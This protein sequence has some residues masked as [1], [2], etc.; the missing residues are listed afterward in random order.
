MKAQYNLGRELEGFLTNGFSVLR[1][2]EKRLDTALEY[3]EKIM[4]TFILAVRQSYNEPSD[5]KKAEFLRKLVKHVKRLNLVMVHGHELDNPEA[6]FSSSQKGKKSKESQKKESR[7]EAYTLSA[8][9]ERPNGPPKSN[10]VGSGLSSSLGSSIGPIGTSSPRADSSK[11]LIGAAKNG[12]LQLVGKYILM[13]ADINFQDENK[14]TPLIWAVKANSIDCVERILKVKILASSGLISVGH[15]HKRQL[16]RSH[17]NDAASLRRLFE[18]S[19]DR[20]YSFASSKH[21]YPS[22]E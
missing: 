17:V 5:K 22:N 2:T 7:K 21:R 4:S 12:N 11:A 15:E 8:I 1:K 20:F 3:F 14:M 19:K 10:S 9:L 16:S 6:P 18:P 13:N